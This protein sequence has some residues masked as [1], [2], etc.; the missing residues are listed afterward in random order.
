ME[1][2]TKA[3]ALLLMPPGIIVLGGI[4]GFLLSIYWR[5]LG[6]AVVALSIVALLV[7]SSPLTGKQLLGGLESGVPV[8]HMPDAAEAQRQ[9]G[10]IVVLAGGRRPAALEYGAD[11]V[12]SSTLERLRYAAQLHRQTRLPI[13]ASGGALFDEA[14]S[15]AALMQTTLRR[16]FQVGAQWIESKS[17][18]TFENGQLSYA[19]LHAAGITRIYLVTHAWHMPRSLW[20]FRRAG[21]DVI[22][23][24]MGFTTLDRSERA[25]LGYLP[26]ASGLL[27]SS[28]AIH[29]RLG[30]VWYKFKYGSEGPAAVKS[31]PPAA[32]N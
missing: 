25:A 26:S 21:F 29:E 23:A 14:I 4:V 31:R 19:I 2:W 5:G 28:I 20:S 11:D 24:P 9:A 7:V 8:L 27:R 6:N 12:S 17:R 15:E 13:L 18:N 10:A 22:P 3:F 32:A 16:D 1:I 30:L